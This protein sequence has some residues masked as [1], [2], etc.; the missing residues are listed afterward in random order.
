MHKAFWFTVAN[1]GGKTAYWPHFSGA[2][3]IPQTY[4]IIK[5]ES[6]MLKKIQKLLIKNTGRHLRY[7]QMID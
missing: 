5:I 1:G 4:N 2:T 7:V 6:G 3:K